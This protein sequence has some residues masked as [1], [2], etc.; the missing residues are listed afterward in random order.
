MVEKMML[1]GKGYDI[2]TAEN[3]VKGLEMAK[4]TAPDL[5]LLDVMMPE[6]DGLEMCR[7]LRADPETANLPV[8]M[9]TTRGE[10]DQV[11]EAFLAGCT[12]YLTKPIDK[13]E[14]IEKVEKFL[15]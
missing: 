5:V 2:E 3:G 14:L 8:L 4:S 7:R 10:P 9:V 6:M 12:D 11:E 1:A 13:L 15:A